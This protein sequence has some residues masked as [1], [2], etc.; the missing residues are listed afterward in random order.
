MLAIALAAKM[1][2][3]PLFQRSSRAATSVLTA[4]E[5]A[6][7]FCGPKTRVGNRN[8]ASHAASRNASP[9][10]SAALLKSSVSIGSKAG[11]LAFGIANA[12]WQHDVFMCIG[13]KSGC[14][15]QNS[16]AAVWEGSLVGSDLAIW[17]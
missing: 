8:N 2:K 16:T 15:E 9:L 17:A 11:I 7:G 13:V 14:K 4:E 1:S 3:C 6:P 5:E 10:M 12:N